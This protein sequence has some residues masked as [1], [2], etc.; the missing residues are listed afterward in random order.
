[1]PSSPEARARAGFVP[2]LVAAGG[3][4][5][6]AVAPVRVQGTSPAAERAR[7]HAA[8]WA[9]GRAEALLLA[10]RGEQHRLAE[11]EEH[12]ARTAR[13][14]DAARARALSALQHAAADRSA[15]DDDL[16]D[17]VTGLV[18]ELAG[19]LAT[20]LV[21][22]ATP[23]P[24]ARAAVERAL[25]AAGDDDATLTVRLHP[26]DVDALG[27]PAAVPGAELRA[28]PT[29]RP[30]D[31]IAFRGARRVD[32]RVRDA[33]ARALASLTDATDDT[34]GLRIGATA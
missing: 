18:M 19:E 27:G 34:D 29:L 7:A 13:E 11:H 23:V 16:T 25:A 15:E 14:A 10:A 17:R 21:G 33:V 9:A 1:M 8:G 3:Q 2:A 4:T 30:G 12:L 22:A 26:D 28:D 31:A 32:A 20:S 6:A 5:R 24:R